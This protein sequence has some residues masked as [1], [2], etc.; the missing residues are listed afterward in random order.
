MITNIDREEMVSCSYLC[1]Y[2][3][4]DEQIMKYITND[5][6]VNVYIDTKNAITAIHDPRVQQKLLEDYHSGADKYVITKTIIILAN[7]W[8]R[9]FKKR[10]IVCNIFFFDE[11]GNS[12]FHN[13]INKSYKAN[14]LTS[15]RR[16]A[17]D[18]LIADDVLDKF[19]IL[20]DKNIALLANLFKL[21]NNVYYIR[22]KDLESD[23]I[24]KL[25]IN[26][27][28]TSNGVLDPKYIHFICSNDKDYLQ[29]LDTNNVFQLSRLTKKNTW[30]VRTSLNAVEKFVKTDLLPEHKLRNSKFIPL[31]IA[32]AGDVIDG[33]G[34]LKG[35][36][37]TGLYKYLNKLYVDKIIDD[38]DYHID[39]FIHKINEYKKI[40]PDRLSDKTTMLILSNIKLI[41]DNY[42]LA[43]FKEI[44]EWLKLDQKK[45]IL[46]QLEK[47][48]SNDIQRR[49]L[50][51][52]VCLYEKSYS[53]LL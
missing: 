23:F 53:G 2:T 48:N 44:M 47:E 28:F 50:L 3:F 37:Y 32:I 1:K 19:T 5:K 29:L 17:S 39:S 31:M 4:I 10:G 41:Q 16:I 42:K 27:Y 11:R 6:I 30:E 21:L 40:N 20:Y 13:M 46:K 25:L 22:L 18:L 14:R 51:S 52:Q 45:M 8:L 38:D 49:Y 26:E 35:V 12:V 43:S 15:K 7:H 9:Y 34:G 24:P 36:G 33:I